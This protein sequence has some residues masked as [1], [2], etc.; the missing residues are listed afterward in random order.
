MAGTESELGR[1]LGE[2]NELLLVQRP[3]CLLKGHA[4]YSRWQ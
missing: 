3:P 1:C 2:R 4:K